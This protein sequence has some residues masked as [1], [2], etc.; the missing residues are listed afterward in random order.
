MADVQ[1]LKAIV[2]CVHNL[3]QGRIPIWQN[4]KQ[5]LQK[6]KNALRILCQK[7]LS[8]KKKK[9]ATRV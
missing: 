4:A 6:Y 2:E 8:L 9:D 5:K 3:A 7:S 1:E